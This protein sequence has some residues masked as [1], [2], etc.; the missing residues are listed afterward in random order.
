MKR[1]LNNPLPAKNTLP[2]SSPN[3][4]VYYSR[5]N[6]HHEN[7]N[8]MTM[9]VASTK[10]LNITYRNGKAPLLELSEEKNPTLT[11]FNDGKQLPHA[12]TSGDIG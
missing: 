8:E 10:P 6:N 7:I 3:Q 11:H 2:P 4:G 1:N 5:E 12:K 9:E